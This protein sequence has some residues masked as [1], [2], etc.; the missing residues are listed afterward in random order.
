MADKVAVSF[1]FSTWTLVA[2]LN[3]DK[4]YDACHCHA[5]GFD[6]EDQKEKKHGLHLNAITV[7][8]II[9]HFVIVQDY[10]NIF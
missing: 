2:I 4:Q 9:N 6:C 1:R 3:S 10:L 7:F 8:K 5:G